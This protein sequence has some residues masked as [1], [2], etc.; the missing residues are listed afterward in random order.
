MDSQ[1][2]LTIGITV[3]VCGLIAIGVWIAVNQRRSRRL[4][5]QFG[6]EY[7][8][9]VE[10]S[11]NRTSAE[12]ELQQREERV[13][14]YKIVALSEHDRTH[15]QHAWDRVQNRFVDDPRGAAMEA[16]ELIFEV[17][18]RRGYPVNGFEQAAAD[19]S[20]DHAVVVENYRAAS[21]IAQRNRQGEAGT[22]D[23]R[24]ALVYYRALF[25]DLLQAPSSDKPRTAAATQRAKRAQSHNSKNSRGGL[26]A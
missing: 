25:H 4:K 12:E 14:E 5:E 7:D 11:G 26:R 8:R 18:E 15:Y 24:Q 13:K 22:E 3:A 23:L 20:V 16:D 19:L 1:T 6:P 2:L 9:V 17:M 21:A 10:R